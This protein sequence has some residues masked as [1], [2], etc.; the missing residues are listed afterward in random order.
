MSDQLLTADSSTAHREAMESLARPYY[1]PLGELGQATPIGPESL[2]APNHSLL[3]HSGHMTTTLESFHDSLVDVHVV[4]EIR[5]NEVY[6]RH[7][8]LTRQSDG[9]VVQSGIMK[10]AL[11][12]LPGPVRDQIAGGDCPLGRILIANNVLREVELLALWRFNTGPTLAREL[13]VDPS[14]AVY[15][16]SARILVEKRPAV[17]L[18]EIVRP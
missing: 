3:A 4:A 7:S 2:D 13:S 9:R 11:V 5:S 8:I 17:E 1:E 18:L 6:Q 10:I 16:R 12:G 15:G 14:A